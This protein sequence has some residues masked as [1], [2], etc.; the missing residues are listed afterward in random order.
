[1]YNENKTAGSLNDFKE[2]FK[3]P[4]KQKLLAVTLL[5]CLLNKNDDV[6]VTP[7]SLISKTLGM[8]ELRIE[9]EKSNTDIRLLLNLDPCLGCLKMHY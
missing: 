6:N 3:K 7:K 1:M 4:R 2:R 5:M 8:G 9:Y